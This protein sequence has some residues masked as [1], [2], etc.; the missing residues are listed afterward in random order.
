MARSITVALELDDR[1]FNRGI[2]SAE[3]N[4]Q[5]FDRSTR[6]AK[7]GLGTI[8]AGFTAAA[9]AAVGLASSL[10]VAS[11]VENL[12]VTL[13]LLYGDADRA[14]DA[15]NIVKAEAAGLSVSLGDIQTGVPSLALV[16]EKFGGLGQAIQFTSGI[17]QGFNMSFQEAASNVQRA[18]SAGIASADLFRDSGVKA[19]LGFQEGVEYTA[20]QTQAQFLAMF[21][22]VTAANKDAAETMSGQ[23]S[24]VQDALFQVQEAMGTAFG[25]TIKALLKDFNAVFAENKETILE[26]ARAIGEN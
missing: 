23:F 24:M 13:K 6:S 1:G 2:N 14:A 20:E 18:L 3:R 11:Q 15:L 5:G 7:V 21:E 4:V 16:E 22:K 26:T 8:A 25:E 17:A 19:F 9:S 12:G 10:N